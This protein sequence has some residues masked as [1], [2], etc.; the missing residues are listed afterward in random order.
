MDEVLN[1]RRL[2][3]LGGKLS[4]NAMDDAGGDFDLFYRDFIVPL[5]KLM[6]AGFFERLTEHES[7]YE[8]GRR[9]D[10]ADIVGG[11]NTKAKLD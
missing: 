1:Q 9:F 10:R 6:K 11:V 8:G 7:Y 3:T 5:R 4:W 2:E